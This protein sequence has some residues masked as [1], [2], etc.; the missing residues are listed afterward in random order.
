MKKIS[1]ILLLTFLT[2]CF[3]SGCKSTPAKP[4]TGETPAAPLGGTQSSTSPT[5]TR[6]PVTSENN[7]AAASPAQIESILLSATQILKEYSLKS[8][9]SRTEGEVFIY[10]VLLANPSGDEVKI[11]LRAGRQP[12]E[13][14]TL[15]SLSYPE[16]TQIDVSSVPMG[17]A[18]AGYQTDTGGVIAFYKGVSLVILQQTMLSGKEELVILAKAAQAID[19]VLP[20][21]LQI[22]IILPTLKP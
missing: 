11:V 6:F 2:A 17:E 3:F 5:A 7:P 15:K 14:N 10:E 18:A 8:A 9:Q 13:P 20:A 1:L 19:A 16:Y 21:A 22:P 4:N 12:V